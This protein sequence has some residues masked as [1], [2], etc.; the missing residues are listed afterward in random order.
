M[1]TSLKNRV[2]FSNAIAC[3]AL[4]AALGG[5]SYAAAQITSA[6]IKDGTITTKDVRNKSLLARDFKPGQLPAGPQGA[7]GPQGPQGEPGQQGERG[8]VGPTGAT[9]PQGAPGLTGVHRVTAQ[10]Y[11]EAGDNHLVVVASCP[12]GEKVVGTGGSP[13]GAASPSVEIRQILPTNDLQHV[14]VTGAEDEATT[15]PWGVIAYAICAR[16]S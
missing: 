15:G 8:P 16:T 4:F 6:A 14:I 12:A 9:G 1:L 10:D 5:T 3:I 11:S 7:T 13:T 2:T